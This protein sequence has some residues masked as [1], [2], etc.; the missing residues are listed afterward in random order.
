MEGDPA[1]AAYE[2]FAAIYND[3][4][5]SNDYEK[6][7]GK[8]L[9]PE[10]RRHGMREG[11]KVLDV[12]CGTGRA[13]RP[14][15]RRGW[16]VHGC[17]LSPAMLR[18][19]AEEGGPEVAL[20]V[21]DM[22][23]LPQTGG[24]NLIL[25]LNDSLNYLLAEADLGIALAGMRRNLAADGLIVF[26]V[27]S[28]STYESGYSGVRHVEH[29]GSQ[30]LWSG[31]GEVAPSIFEAEITGDGLAEP[32]RHLERFHP[33]RNVLE[34]MEVAG[35][36]TLATLG[37]REDADQI[38]LSPSPD[39]LRDYKLIYIGTAATRVSALDLQAEDGRPRRHR[40][41]GEARAGAAGHARSAQG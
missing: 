39:E 7:L 36:E 26:D 5:H 28:S 9:L 23:D 25:S 16:R 40:V 11:G 8:V 37:M 17:D 34:A 27:N 1:L 2:A 41:R 18:I 32:I 10:L 19:A 4:N 14:L 29:E 20:R 21:A 6:W 24:F 35:F 13:F 31:R 33:Q 22:R 38:L 3:F 30:W 15:L 12:A